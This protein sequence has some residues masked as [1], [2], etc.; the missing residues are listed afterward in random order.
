VLL[1]NG[2]KFSILYCHLHA[3]LVSFVNKKMNNYIAM[4][5]LCYESDVILQLTLASTSLCATTV[6]VLTQNLSAITSIP[7]ATTLMSCMAVK[8]TKMI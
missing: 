5:T 2:G 8:R 3:R 6:G 4:S 1:R 7:V